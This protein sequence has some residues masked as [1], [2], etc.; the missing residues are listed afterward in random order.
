M[1]NRLTQ[2]LKKLTISQQFMLASLVILVLGMAGVG[3][4]IETQIEIGVINRAGAATALYVDSFIAPMLQELGQEEDLLPEHIADLGKLLSESPLGREIVAVKV[5]TTRGRL[6]FSTDPSLEIGR[7]YPMSEGLLNARLGVVFS[8]ISQLTG[9]E[10]LSLKEQHNHLLEIY[11]PVWLSGTNQVIAVAEFYQRADELDLEIE[12]LKRQSWFVVGLVLILM[13]FL[14]SGFVRTTSE[15]IIHQQAELAQ[16]VKQLTSLLAQNRK[17][18]ARVRKAAASVAILNES[19]LR[20]VGLEI[21]DG[22]TQEIGLAILKIDT[23]LG[24]IESSRQAGAPRLI[25]TLAG[26]QTSLQSA[27]QELRAIASGMSLPELTGLTLPETIIRV[28]RAHE[29]RTGNA[30]NLVLDDIPEQVSQ[31]LKITVYRIIQEALNNSFRHGGGIAQQ[32]QAR[33]TSEL[34]SVEIS[35]QGPGF[36]PETLPEAEGHLGI[37]G[38]RERVE[39]IGGEF[40]LHS[41]EGRGTI[42][43][44]SLP[45]SET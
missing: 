35:D 13:Y 36:D 40:K 45:L 11:S 4:W 31:P 17:L 24:E 2:P 33:A 37:R 38:M 5:W 41:S 21:H 44:A 28:V 10:N 15:T 27:L 22:P 16:S 30:V 12:N 9:E 6:L 18:S 25:E 7:T 8:E 26:V 32:V 19:N 14:L 43:S 20:R 23:A 3:A 29:R 34:L 39:S 42:M 1:W